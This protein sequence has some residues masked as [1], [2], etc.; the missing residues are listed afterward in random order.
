MRTARPGILKLIHRSYALAS[1]APGHSRQLPSAKRVSSRSV[2]Q[3]TSCSLP[4]PGLCDALLT[5]SVALNAHC[6]FFVT[7]WLTIDRFNTPHSL[8]PSV[9]V[10]AIKLVHPQQ[11]IFSL[12]TLVLSGKYLERVWGQNGFLQF[13]GVVVVVSNV[14]AVIVNVVEHFVFQDA[15]M[16]L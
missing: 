2:V 13:V 10:P 15:G 4:R 8:R 5:V 16:L 7:R 11:F 14:L 1:T 12:A 6:V 9:S 3:H